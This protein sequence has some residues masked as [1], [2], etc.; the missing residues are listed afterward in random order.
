MRTTLKTRYALPVGWAQGLSDAGYAVPALLRDAQLSVERLT[1]PSPRLTTDEYFRLWRAVE[2]Q[3][4]AEAPA[5]ALLEQITHGTFAPAVIATL[6]SPT[7][8]AGFTRLSRFK[9]LLGPLQLRVMRPSKGLEIDLF[10]LDQGDRVPDS[11]VLLEL[12]T[13]VRLSRLGTDERLVPKRVQAPLHRPASAAYARFFG[14]PIQPG[15]IISLQFSSAD[16][17]RPFLTADR[18]LSAPL[19]RAP[20]SGENRTPEQPKALPNDYL[21]KRPCLRGSGLRAP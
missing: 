12:L 10:F 16:A 7:L 17:E 21:A 9:A 3:S 11:L 1:D 6:C 14:T 8:A 5:L 20:Q 19:P 4:A 18:I 2:R 13:L 15:T